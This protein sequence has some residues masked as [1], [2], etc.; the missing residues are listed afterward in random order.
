M[1][2][3]AS[4]GASSSTYGY[5]RREEM[6]GGGVVP[7]PL[8]FFKTTLASSFF[9]SISDSPCGQERSVVFIPILE[10]GARVSPL[11]ATKRLFL[12]WCLGDVPFSV[13]N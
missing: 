7:R 9:F 8:S 11:A 1:R 6:D 3:A 4:L 2:K 5:E 10:P 12:S 13:P